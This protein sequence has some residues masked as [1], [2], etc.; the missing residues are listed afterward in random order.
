MSHES[1][2]DLSVVISKPP[3]FAATSSASTIEGP[4]VLK[5]S[6]N[7]LSDM[8]CHQFVHPPQSAPTSSAAGPV[9]RIFMPG[10][11]YMFSPALRGTKDSAA[12]CLATSCDLWLPY[13]Y[14]GAKFSMNGSSKSPASFL[15]LMIL[16]TA[17][18]ILSSLMRPSL[19][20]AM[21]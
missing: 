15:T 14:E 6:P 19:T 5:C 13:S 11:M 2:C 4:S 7:S 10:S 20:A 3:S 18:L 8:P 17:S 12:S 16:V 1:T 21:M 9:T